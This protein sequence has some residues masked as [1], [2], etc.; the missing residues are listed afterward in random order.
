MCSVKASH[1]K[2]PR[3]DS[4]R[5]HNCRDWWQSP[6][7]LLLGGQGY[8]MVRGVNSLVTLLVSSI[9]TDVDFMSGL[10]YT[11]GNVVPP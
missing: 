7:T 2:D 6:A 8:G 9:H 11:A 3:F 4:R 5:P 1:A 10:S